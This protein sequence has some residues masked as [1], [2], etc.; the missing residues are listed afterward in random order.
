MKRSFAY[1]L[2]VVFL[3]GCDGEPLVQPDLS[4]NG[5]LQGSWS[6]VSSSGGIGG[7]TYTPTPIEDYNTTDQVHLYHTLIID[8]STMELRV[9]ND[10]PDGLL[11]RRSTFEV[12]ENPDVDGG[13]MI[14]LSNNL[15]DAVPD[16]G[17]TIGFF[18]R[19]RL[20]D[21]TPSKLTFSDDCTDCFTHEFSKED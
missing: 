17:G 16:I 10:S 6:W 18:E 8:G 11:I 14:H 2:L 19:V 3:F 5:M 21:L 13:Y 1:T 4:V 15:M 7:W 20:D 9:D 12:R